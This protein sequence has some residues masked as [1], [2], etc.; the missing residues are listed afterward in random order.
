M[1][2][3]T[4]LITDAELL[5][6]GLPGDA[7]SIVDVA[8][9]DSSRAGAS[10]TI[11]GY[12]KKRYTL[13]LLAWGDDLKKVVADEAV[14]DLMR[15]RGFDPGSESGSLIVKGHDDAIAWARDVAKGLIE[16]VDIED[17]TP[18]VDE[19]APL[20]MSDDAAGWTWP[21]TSTSDDGSG[22]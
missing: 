19:A 12:L 11:L 8:V 10:A 13:P 22:C 18:D 7:L 1:A 14:Y 20:V 21:T 4:T 5:A 9:R 17:S 16:P 3:A 2:E 6:F 15:F